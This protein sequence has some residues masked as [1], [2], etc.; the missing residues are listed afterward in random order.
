LALSRA[1]SDLRDET[2]ARF[3]RIK[4]LTFSIHAASEDW[5]VEGMEGAQPAD[6]R[7]V[8]FAS[9]RKIKVNIYAPDRK[10]PGQLLR[11]R[12]QLLNLVCML[13]G[14]QC[15]LRDDFIGGDKS[16]TPQ[17]LLNSQ[18][19]N[20]WPFPPPGRYLPPMAIE[21]VNQERTF[22]CDESEP[23]ISLLAYG[24][25][26][27]EHIVS[28]FEYLRRV[29]AVRVT[30]PSGIEPKGNLSTILEMAAEHMVSPDA[31]GTTTR[32][33]KLL[34]LESGRT[35]RFDRELDDL[36]GPTAAALRLERFQTWEAYVPVITTLIETEEDGGRLDV[37]VRR[38]LE[39]RA[40]CWVDWQRTGNTNAEVAPMGNR[41]PLFL[42]PGC[43]GYLEYRR[44]AFLYFD[45]VD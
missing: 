4:I 32:D 23:T 27:I 16:Q 21:F 33:Q 1:N 13:A 9:F 22:W 7:H 3:K 35:V 2:M 5:T 11:I 8:D 10:D 45:W 6:F 28:V 26:D 39:K 31:F 17:I 36:E 38:P 30:L 43:D 40:E 42:R 19:I 15:V 25:N 41:F 14:L 24:D 20:G 34:K 44:L 37:S 29:T 12:E 18:G